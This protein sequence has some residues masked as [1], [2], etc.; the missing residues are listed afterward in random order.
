MQLVYAI[1]KLDPDIILTQSGD[2]YLFPYLIHRST[3]N[4]VIDEF[5]LSRDPKPF[6][7]K[8]GAGQT[9]F[10]Y[11]TRFIGQAPFDCTGIHVDEN[12]TFVMRESGFDG[13]I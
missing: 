9:F 3:E 1:K 10:S 6:N 11:G 13:F 8:T 5:I 12:N 7:R 2:S 4:G